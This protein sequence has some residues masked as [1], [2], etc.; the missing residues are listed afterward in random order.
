MR[1][2]IAPL[3][4]A[5]IMGLAACRTRSH[6]ERPVGRE[7]LVAVHLLHFDGAPSLTTRVSDSE[8]RRVVAEANRYAPL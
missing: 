4:L 5:M 7:L 3:T 6:G 8:A 1:L 2:K